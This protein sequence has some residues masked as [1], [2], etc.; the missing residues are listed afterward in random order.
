MGCDIHLFVEIKNPQFASYESLFAGEALV[1]RNYQ[2]FAALAGVRNYENFPTLH[3]PRGF[4]EDASEAA[5]DQYYQLIIEDKDAWMFSGL[6][7]VTLSH[8]AETDRLPPSVKRSGMTSE[9]GYIVCPDWHTPS[10]LQL[11]EIHEALA[12]ANIDAGT[13]APGFRVVLE[14]MATAERLFHQP[15][16][17]VFWFDN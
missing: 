7:F 15:T 2:L 9:L 3:R 10:Y 5:V 13:L 12:H 14:T 11:S 8:A 1:E 4:P 17:A 16:R 6:Q